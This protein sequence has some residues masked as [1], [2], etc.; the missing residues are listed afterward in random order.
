MKKLLMAAVAV[1]TLAATPAL[2]ATSA[3]YTVNGNV[4]ATCSVTGTGTITLGE[5]GAGTTFTATDASAACNQGNTTVDVTHVKLQST[6]VATATTGFTRELEFTPKLETQ[7]SAKTVTGDATAAS[8]G[9]FNTLKVT[10]TTGTP[11][12]TL[13]AG[14]YTGSITIT[15]NPAT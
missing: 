9:A 11:T 3:V 10:A 1:S 14:N 12:A 6:T 5:L 2:A 7:D 13:V 8:L 15:L 4:T